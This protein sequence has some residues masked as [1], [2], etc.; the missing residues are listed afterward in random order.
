MKNIKLSDE[1]HE[2]LSEYRDENGHTSIDSAVR[3]LLWKQ[4]SKTVSV[5]PDDLSTVVSSV[6]G[7][8][9]VS[10]EGDRAAE[11][12]REQVDE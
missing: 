11:R 10:L 2:Q 3:E 5:N 1:A 8:R 7:D 4:S 6:A 9:N 12:L